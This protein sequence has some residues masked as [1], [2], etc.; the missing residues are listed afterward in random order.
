MYEY[1]TGK[2]DTVTPTAAIVEAAAIGYY[3]NI[4][5]Q[6]FSAIEKESSVKLF[7]H[8]YIVQN[9]APVFY[10]FATRT[11]REMFRLLISVSGIGAN[12]AR[13]MLSSFSTAEL[14]TAIATGNVAAIK[15][16]K[17]IGI[18]TAERTILELKGK[19]LS[20][21]LNEIVSAGGFASAS[22]CENLQEAVEALLV[23]G[24]GK[25][26]VEKVAKALYNE[27]PTMAAEEIIRASLSRL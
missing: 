19:V 26:A 20:V 4:S 2:L 22:A 10:G 8:Q 18:K 3:I 23:L 9:D 5:L 21:E 12:T 1:I 7:L 15:S 14:V 13:I 11:E 25:A 16:V 24:F 17:G 6:T 27:N